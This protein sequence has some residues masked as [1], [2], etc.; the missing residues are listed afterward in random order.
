MIRDDSHLEQLRSEWTDQ[1]V[2]AR[3]DR[4]DLKRFAGRVGRVVT[5]NCNARVLVDFADGAWYDLEPTSLI[6]VTDENL[7]AKYNPKVNSAQPF[8][9][10]QS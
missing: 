6:K 7:I 2:L 3:A 1:Y 4:P 5:V 9:N 8:P 10:K